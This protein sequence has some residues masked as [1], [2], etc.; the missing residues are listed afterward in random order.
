M[1]GTGPRPWLAGLLALIY[2]GLGHVYVRSWG[3]ALLWFALS[4]ATTLFVVPDEVAETADPIANPMAA[5]EAIVSQTPTLGV[6][7]ILLVIA[8]SMVDAYLTARRAGESTAADEETAPSESETPQTCPECGR[9]V[10]PDL[11]FC[12]WCSAELPENEDES[13][14]GGGSIVDRLR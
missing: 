10:D 5:S 8:F 14:S 7:S 11:S 9:E 2:P 13:S 3:R 6:V 12:H 4:I 1:S